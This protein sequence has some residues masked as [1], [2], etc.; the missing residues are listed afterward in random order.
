[1]LD[2]PLL[3]TALAGDLAR[4]AARR[5][6]RAVPHVDRPHFELLAALWTGKNHTFPDIA[7]APNSLG[8]PPDPNPLRCKIPS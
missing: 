4:L 5:A 7:P 6:G 3:R 2:E 1:M 8:A